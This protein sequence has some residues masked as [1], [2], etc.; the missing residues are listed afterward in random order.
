MPLGPADPDPFQ[1]HLWPR[2]PTP[3]ICDH[4]LVGS[5]SSLHAFA[6]VI[7]S[8]WNSLSLLPI[9]KSFKV[10]LQ[11]NQLFRVCGLK[12]T[13]NH[14]HAQ[15]CPLIYSHCILYLPLLWHV[16]LKLDFTYF[17]ISSSTRA[18]SKYLLKDPCSAAEGW[19]KATHSSHTLCLR[20]LHFH[21]EERHL[22]LMLIVI[23]TPVLFSSF[24]P[25][26]LSCTM[27]CT[28]PWFFCIH[29]VMEAS[30]T[31]D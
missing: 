4:R 20:P 21:P 13:H 3:P 16:T 11:C 22:D 24:S 5:L 29:Q 10:H 27:V 18:A 12:R 17:Y 15:Y 19:G 14:T 28:E 31:H 1:P 25:P 26:S 7:C 9:A 23:I 6:P 8:A 30:E 2:L